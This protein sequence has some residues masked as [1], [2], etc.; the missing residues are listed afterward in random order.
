M[1]K[2]KISSL[3]IENFKPFENTSIDF[4]TASMITL[5]GPNGFGKTSI[6]DA[7]ELLF[8]G[9]I[10]RIINTNDATVAKRSRKKQF[11][12]NIYWNRNKEGDI[13]IRAELINQD[14]GESIFL[15]RVATIADLS[16]PDNNAP[17]NFSIFKLYEISSIDS[18]KFGESLDSKALESILGENFLK[19]FSLL[20]YLEQ[21][22]N[23]YLYSTDATERKKGIE[24]LINTDKLTRQ[25]SYCSEL[26][27]IITESY[28]GKVHTDLQAELNEK[29]KQLSGQFQDAENSVDFKRLSTATPSPCWD[30]EQPLSAVNDTDIETLIRELRNIFRIYQNFDEVLTRKANSN[31]DE[32]L[33]REVDIKL[34]LQLGSEVAGYEGLKVKE[35][36]LVGL[37]HDLLIFRKPASEINEVDLNGLKNAADLVGVNSLIEARDLIKSDSAAKNAKLVNLLNAHAE[38]LRRHQECEDLEISGCPFCGLSWATYA[39]LEEAAVNNAERIRSEID[40]SAQKLEE[41][42]RSIQDLLNLQITAFTQQRDLVAK[43]FDSVLFKALTAA[44]SK[45]SI[46]SEVALQL[47]NYGVS[48]DLSFTADDAALLLRFNEAKGIIATAKKPEKDVLPLDWSSSL[49]MAF[50][51]ASDITSLSV[52][53]FENKESY[54]RAAHSKF[55]SE[56]Y[57]SKV[58]E[59]DKLSSRI[60]AGKKIKAKIV[61]LRRQLDD[62]AKQYAKKTIGDI[63]LLFHIYSGRLIQNYQRGLGLFIVSG[64]GDILK[65]NTALKSDHDAILSMSSGQIASLGLAFFLTLNRVYALNPFILIDDPVQSM[66]EINIASLSDLL[67]VELSDRQILLSNHEMEVSTYIRYK[68]K[69][70]GLSQASFSMLPRNITE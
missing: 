18:D 24:H 54:L 19:N 42:V 8:T 16:N 20:N 10:Q 26:E 43:D 50:L 56:E 44:E 17:D 14:S 25:I 31:I 70:A 65:F 34:A 28:T 35:S 40:A 2:W 13:A 41:T 69:R 48:K 30:V 49:E 12:E 59:L 61:N 60:E 37:D 55:K 57:K 38:L 29:I 5:D 63:E 27:S 67:R 39:A 22:Q 7:L 3:K 53:D 58:A 68:F 6:F 9:V 21:G 32:F 45:F 33:K 66:D 4:R 62:T 36:T 46:I 1:K 15:A 64:K 11:E 47:V 51:N 52:S 23:R